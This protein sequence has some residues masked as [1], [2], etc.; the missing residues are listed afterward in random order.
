MLNARNLNLLKQLVAGAVGILALGLTAQAQL[1]TGSI[2]FVGG[3]VINNA[4][5]NATS[6]T[7]FYGPSGSGSDPVVQ[8]GQET[9]AYAA[10]NVGNIPVAFTPFTFS[11]TLS[12]SGSLW[13]FTYSGTTYS[14]DITSVDTD[15]QN[16]YPLGGGQYL[17]FL[18]VGGNGTATVSGVGSTPAT[19]SITGTT[20][21]SFAVTITMGSSV[22][23]V[24][25]PS[26]GVFM[27]AGLGIC[28]CGLAFRQ[29]RQ[30]AVQR[31]RR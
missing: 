19:W 6:F 30:L 20:A 2:S 12:I 23:A 22:N 24:P 16:L 10:L 21:S 27:V 25:E 17:G 14:F 1:F 28:V 26:A 11:P 18:N 15:V 5:P 9:G 13:N 29:R 31:R 8:G 3:A 7:S 4:I